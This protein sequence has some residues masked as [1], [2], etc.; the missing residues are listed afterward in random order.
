MPHAI[1]KRSPWSSRRIAANLRPPHSENGRTMVTQPALTR[2]QISR[3]DI[4]I[5]VV[6]TALGLALMASNTWDTGPDSPG[7]VSFLAVPTFLAVTL[8][9]LWRSVDPLRALGV[10]TA[11]LVLHGVAFGSL[12]RCGVAFPTV[13]LLAFAA[14]A[15]LDARESRIA[16]AVGVGA[17]LLVGA[18]EFIGFGVV[19]AGIPLLLLCWGFGRVAHSRGHLAGEL[20]ARNT[21]LQRTRDERARIEVASDRAQLSGELDELLQ[22]RLHELA[23]LADRGPG[24]VSDGSAGALLIDIE[25]ESRETLDHMRT[26]VGVLRSDDRDTVTPQPSLTSLD[27]LLVRSRGGSAELTIGGDPRVLPAGVE[28]TAYR[29]VEHLLDTLDDAPGVRVDVHFAPDALEV[30]VEGPA[31]KHSEVSVALE[32]ARARVESQRGSLRT[33]TRDGRATTVAAL[34]LGI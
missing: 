28:L 10:V 15:R 34:P 32:R 16:L 22:R 4:A 1:E 33:S 9:L 3:L 11:A 25:R 31:R 21:E 30:S 19:T 8:P 13:G 27:A 24:S 7:D 5:T 2:S 29:V 17:T 23:E 14:A 20:R 12:V 26:L 18:F 6:L